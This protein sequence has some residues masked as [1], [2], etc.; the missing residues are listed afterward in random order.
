MGLSDFKFKEADFAGKKIADL[1]DTPSSDGMG[2]A[3][4]KAY[5]DYIP[6]AMIAL[7]VINGIIDELGSTAGAGSI[8]AAVSDVTGIDVQTILSSLKTLIDDRYTK[9][10]VDNLLDSKASTTTVSGM[11]ASVDFDTQTGVFTFTEQGGTVHTF[12]TALEQVV[13]NWDYDEQTQKLVLT[14]E[15]GETKNIDLS[16][17]VTINEFLNSDTIDFSVNGAKVTANIKQGS[18]TDSM[19]ESSLLTAIQTY[20]QSCQNDA[21]TA[22]AAASNA[23]SYSDTASAAATA[24]GN[25]ERSAAGSASS[26]ATDAGKAENEAKK[27]QSYAVGGTG[28][29]QGEDTDNAKYYAQQAREAAGQDFV[30]QSELTTALDGKVDKEAGKGLSKNDYNDTDKEKV[31][32]LPTDTNVELNKKANKPTTIT[33]TLAI[34]STSII[35]TS[36]AITE[37]S[38]VSVFT[39]KYDVSPINVVAETGKVTLTFEVQTEV[40]SVKVEVATSG[41]Y[42]GSAFIQGEL[43]AGES[44][45]TLNDSSIT[46]NSIV[47]VYTDKYPVA[48]KSITVENGTITV[49]FKP[50]TTKMQVKVEVR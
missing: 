1:S 17:F 6:K 45:L 24:A 49:V 30:T 42:G 21:Q 34:G 38:T 5:F 39:S 32:N 22:S 14:L 23:G 8:G 16:A 12:D 25:S 28:T 33:G 50:Q 15:S 46:A 26:A 47:N 27:A 9:S 48:A 7:G 40:I 18:I 44:T 35:L 20:A 36:P 43:A 19:F 13:T 29:R 37:N 41:V 10:T 11:I 31:G 4:L 2:A 3:E